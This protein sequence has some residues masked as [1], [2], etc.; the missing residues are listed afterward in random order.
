MRRRLEEEIRECLHQVN[1]N[2]DQL[3]SALRGRTGDVITKAKRKLAKLRDRYAA[4]RVALQLLES[5]QDRRTTGN[6]V[7][8][9][10]AV[11]DLDLATRQARQRYDR[12]RNV[13]M[14]AEL[15][16]VWRV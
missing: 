13:A 6:L 7:D 3:E 1:H 5:R 14:L 9:Q 11:R 15:L 8:L 12:T 2:L 16:S 4:A 10:I